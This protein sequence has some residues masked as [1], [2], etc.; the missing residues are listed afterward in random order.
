MSLSHSLSRGLQ[1]LLMGILGLLDGVREWGK[2]TPG[3]AGPGTRAAARA[4]ASRGRLETAEVV[5]GGLTSA[6][7]SLGLP[8]WTR[9]QSRSARRCSA[10]APA[11]LGLGL[12]LRWRRLPSSGSPGPR[13]RPPAMARAQAL[14]LAL[15]FQFCAPETETPAGKRARSLRAHPASRGRL[16]AR[17]GVQ[18]AR[19]YVPSVCDRCVRSLCAS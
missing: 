4:T 5:P 19:S 18:D 8:L 11:R 13:Q 10:I 17:V 2:G 14:V 6:P 1:M 12:R 3:P 16:V 7:R 15:T 9:L